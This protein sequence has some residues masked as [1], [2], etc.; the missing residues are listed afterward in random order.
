MCTGVYVR[1]RVCEFMYVRMC[2]CVRVS[3]RVCACGVC[4]TWCVAHTD[5]A[6]HFWLK[7]MTSVIL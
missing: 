3:V 5:S 7:R 6:S 4:V 1:A 2:V